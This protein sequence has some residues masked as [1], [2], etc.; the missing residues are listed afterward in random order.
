MDAKEIEKIG[1]NEKKRFDLPR[2]PEF[3][4][5]FV[6]RLHGV[7][8]LMSRNR[9]KTDDLCAIRLDFRNLIV[10]RLPFAALSGKE[11]K[12]VSMELQH[13][14]SGKRDVSMV[15]M[16][17]IKNIPITGNFLLRAIMKW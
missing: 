16:D 8:S 9:V 15:S 12:K 17:R 10:T 6:K 4:E 13:N 3:S 7:R 1:W 11:L 2:L 14:A 5:S